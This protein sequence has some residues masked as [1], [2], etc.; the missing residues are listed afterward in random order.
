MLQLVLCSWTALNQRKKRKISLGMNLTRPP[1]Y[2]SYNKT[3]L[4]SSLISFLTAGGQ[5]IGTVQG[6]W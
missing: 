5:G 4:F 1:D 6:K 3:Y 2:C